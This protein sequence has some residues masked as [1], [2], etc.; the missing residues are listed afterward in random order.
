M[1][2]AGTGWSR[3]RWKYLWVL[4][5]SERNLAVA[6]QAYPL[7]PLRIL[8]VLHEQRRLIETHLA[9]LDAQSEL[10]QSF[11]ELERS[12]GGSIQ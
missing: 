3:N 2:E 7:G 4:S 6:R 8:D 9:Y 11:A 5:Q 10:F 12:V 1:S